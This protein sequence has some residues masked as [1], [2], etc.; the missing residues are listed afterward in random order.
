[1]ASAAAIGEK[2]RFNGLH[3]R[4]VAALSVRLFDDLRTEHGLG[5]RDRLRLEVAALL[6]DVGIFIGLRD[7]HLH[8]QYVLTHAEVFGLS[9]DDM[10]IVANV[11]RYHRG[12]CRRARIRNTWRWIA[13]SALT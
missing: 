1:M 10:A 9:Q 2:Y 13:A 5:D 7:H 11:A 8:S 3:G 6:H 4:Q 12:D